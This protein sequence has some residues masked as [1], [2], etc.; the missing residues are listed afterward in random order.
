MLKGAMLKGAML[1]GDKIDWLATLAAMTDRQE[2]R[3]AQ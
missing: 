3:H 2:N 1:K